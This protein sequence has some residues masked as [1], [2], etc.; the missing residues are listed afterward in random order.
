MD[1]DIEP[2]TSNMYTSIYVLEFQRDV[3]PLDWSFAH[4]LTFGPPLELENGMVWKNGYIITSQIK[5][6]KEK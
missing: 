2:E 6:I 3:C 5:H 1:Q 4:V